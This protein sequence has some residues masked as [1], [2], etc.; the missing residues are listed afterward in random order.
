[1]PIIFKNGNI[2]TIPSCKGC[3]YYLE[4][5]KECIKFPVLDL[6]C[7]HYERSGK[8]KIFVRLSEPKNDWN[9]RFKIEV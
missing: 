8:E 3:K 6:F 5:Q 2:K 1:M 9:N 7:T 4:M